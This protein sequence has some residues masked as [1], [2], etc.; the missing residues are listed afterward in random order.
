MLPYW[1]KNVHTNKC[2]LLFRW[3]LIEN[4]QVL[5]NLNLDY[6]TLLVLLQANM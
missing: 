1:K 6:V 5:S 2:H 4:V 3:C